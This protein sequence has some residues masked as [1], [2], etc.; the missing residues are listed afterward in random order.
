MDLKETAAFSGRKIQEKKFKRAGEALQGDFG[1]N[2]VR[3]GW[4]EVQEKLAK[5]ALGRSNQDDF[6]WGLEADKKVIW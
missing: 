6:G 3:F 5:V 1:I 4:V 2:C